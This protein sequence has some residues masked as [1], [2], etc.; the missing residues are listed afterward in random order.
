MKLIK[1]LAVC[2]SVLGIAALVIIA[3]AMVIKT[4]AP[5]I[6]NQSG[7]CKISSIITTVTLIPLLTHCNK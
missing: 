2:S 7:L 1:V 3:S 6:T 5:H 4:P